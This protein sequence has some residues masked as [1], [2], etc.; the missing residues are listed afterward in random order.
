MERYPGK[1][2][3][4]DDFFI[5]ELRGARRVLNQ[6]Q[7]QTVSGPLAMPCG[8]PWSQPGRVVYDENQRVFHHFYGAEIAGEQ[9]I[10]IQHSHDGF[11][12]QR[13]SLG[14][15]EVDGGRDNNITNCPPG[16]MA[17]FW[18][19]HAEDEDYRWKRI[20]NKPQ[21]QGADGEPVWMA[22]HSRDGCDWRAYPPGPHNDQ[23]MLFNFGSPHETFGGSVDPD[24][25][26]VWYS[27]RGSSRRTR[28]LGRRDSPDGLNWSGLRTV[29]DQDL[30]DP[31]GSEFYAAGFDV[32]NRSEGGLRVLMLDV[33]HTDLREPYLIDNPAAYWGGEKGG[34]AL[35]ARV[36]GVVEA[37]L[38]VSRD[39]VAWTRFRE[40]FIARGAPGA[41]DWGAVYADGPI[42][43]DGQL[44]FFYNGHSLTHNG[45]APQ[46][47]QQPYAS[48]DRRGKGLALLRVDGYVSVEAESYAPG[49]LTT[50]RFRQERGGRVQVNVDAAAGELRYELLEDNGAPIP[51]YTAAEC[52]PI[53]SDELAAELSWQGRKGWPP[54]GDARRAAVP[55][56]S[57]HD[58]YVKLRFCI[59]P[60][61]K[62]YSLT[63]DPPEVTQWQVQLRGRID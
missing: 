49:V 43:H 11:S 15:V 1:Q 54:L 19:P 30:G 50:H 38:S 59:A 12:W 40:P 55:G 10:C 9:R 58:F 4:I 31:P 21:G 8:Y 62:L 16:G 41:W 51:G 13:P 6:P 5:E 18:D 53:R 2:L 42:L 36:D 29:I 39:T 17:I 48:E 37:Q 7:K 27:Q 32:A 63:L 47:W 45:R 33:F 24:A 23:Q 46:L 52:D 14:L 56:L 20:D 26:Y 57:E 61:T 35:A 3:F 60:G 28:V 22:F 44:Y 34:R 25:R